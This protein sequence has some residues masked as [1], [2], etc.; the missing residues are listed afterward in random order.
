[1]WRQTDYKGHSAVNIL[2]FPILEDALP[3]NILVFM[4]MEAMQDQ[5]LLTEGTTL[6][7]ARYFS[8]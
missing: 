2:P 8:R 7:K 4:Q 3:R 6:S 1:M 5:L